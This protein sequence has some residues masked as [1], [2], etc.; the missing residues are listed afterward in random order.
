MSTLHAIYPLTLLYDASCPVC[1]LEMDELRHRDR[2]G[3][4]AFVDISTPGFDLA[5]HWPDAASGASPN[6][7]DLN[8]ALHG[9][10]ANGTVYTGVETIRLAY[11]AVG[12]GWLWAP[13][14]WPVLRP[15]FDVAYRVFARHRYAISARLAPFVDRLAQ[16]R[17]RSHDRMQRCH[18]AQAQS[19]GSHCDL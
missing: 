16:R 4:L 7:F 9:I 8:A 19:P 18:D 2:A 10:G 13:T 17:A 1:R 5:V 3:R 15:V 11:A 14:G 12:L 6:V